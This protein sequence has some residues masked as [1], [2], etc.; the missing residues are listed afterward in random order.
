L[1]EACLR[2]GPSLRDPILLD[3]HGIG[4]RADLTG[5]CA[6]SARPEV[7]HGLVIAAVY[8]PDD[9]FP[10]STPRL[11]GVPVVVVLIAGAAG[12][13]RSWGSGVTRSEQ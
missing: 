5:S 12:T 3:G 4:G 13:R 2:A 7:E 10:A 1:R 11:A 6:G 8:E 9:E